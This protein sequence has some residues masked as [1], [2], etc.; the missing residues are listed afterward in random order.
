MVSPTK[1]QRHQEERLTAL[2]PE[3]VVTGVFYPPPAK[4]A[5]GIN[6]E[7]QPPIRK[8]ACI[9]AT[10]R[11]AADNCRGR[12]QFSRMKVA[13]KSPASRQTLTLTRSAF[14]EAGI[15]HLSVGPDAR[16]SPK[17]VSATH[18]SKLSP[19][20]WTSVARPSEAARQKIR[21][22]PAFMRGDLTEGKE[23]NKGGTR[24]LSSHGGTGSTED[25][26][27]LRAVC[28]NP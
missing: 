11:D 21:Q 16:C 18:C 1:V 15:S 20:C 22:R 5:R 2:K 3:K 27:A 8:S 9:R 25:G 13:Q 19:C 10:G 14:A 4:L 24:C 26:R 28:L 6:A 23:G 12:I 17:N 7:N